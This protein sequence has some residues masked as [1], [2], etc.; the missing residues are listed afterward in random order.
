MFQMLQ[1]L[2]APSQLTL[3]LCITLLLSSC[4]TLLLGAA[5]DV[6]L[7]VHLSLVIQ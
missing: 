3:L 6:V 7:A 4:T 5:S 2:T 1:L